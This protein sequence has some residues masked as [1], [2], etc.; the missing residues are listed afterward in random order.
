[1]SPRRP[2]ATGRSQALPRRTWDRDDG[3]EEHP[4]P[5]PGTKG[6]PVQPIPWHPH[7]GTNQANTAVHGARPDQRLS[8]DQR[9]A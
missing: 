8:P 4:G 7:A 3:Q 2:I 9:P 5:Q 1:L 6:S